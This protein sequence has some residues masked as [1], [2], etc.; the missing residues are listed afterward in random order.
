MFVR[1]I[2]VIA[3]LAAFTTAPALAQDATQAP[4]AAKP[5][6]EKK[7][8]RYETP[9]GSNIP[10]STCHTKTEW[11]QIDSAQQAYTDEMKHAVIAG[12]SQ[13]H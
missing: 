7:V 5:V 3:L 9:T 4:A 6:K 11:A 12:G 1:R 10:V 13:G 8:C 2:A